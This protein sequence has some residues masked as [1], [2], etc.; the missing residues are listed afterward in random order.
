MI[1]TQLEVNFGE[2][3]CWAYHDEGAELG[4]YDFR[5]E[6][7]YCLRGGAWLYRQRQ[8]LA[9]YLRPFCPVMAGR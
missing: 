7:R 1:V 2:F 8:V 9:V 5:D 6:D 3:L 4:L